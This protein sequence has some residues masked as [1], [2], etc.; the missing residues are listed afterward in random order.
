M[1][2]RDTESVPFM[3]D[4]ENDYHHS[5]VRKRTML[6]RRFGFLLNSHS[7]LRPIFKLALLVG[8]LTLFTIAVI[9]IYDHAIQPKYTSR[10]FRSDYTCHDHSTCRHLADPSWN[11]PP[12]A[13][14]S[15]STRQAFFSSIY[16]D[17]Y[18]GGALVLGYTLRKHQPHHVLNMLHIPGRISSSTA[19]A[20]REVGWSLRPVDRVPPPIKGVHDHFRDQFTKLLIWNMTDYD[21]IVYLDADTIT[22]RP[23][24]QLFD[25]IREGSFEFA[26]APDN[27]FGKFTFN[28][29]AGMLVLHPSSYVLDEMLTCHGRAG[30][31]QRVLS[32]S[33]YLFAHHLQHERCLISRLSRSLERLKE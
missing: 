30:V 8:S 24:N 28:L 4:D 1:D 26:A 14:G 20:L 22:L 6:N 2:Q 7:R 33:L 25:L 18:I 3:I 29:N 10:L 12:P 31:S 32:L 19:C 11:P 16:T 23:I 17:D 21:A 9:M 13:P 15:N 27:W 5:S